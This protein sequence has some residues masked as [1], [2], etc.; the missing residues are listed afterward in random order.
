[1]L[2]VKKS[3]VQVLLSPRIW[4]GLLFQLLKSDKKL[5]WKDRPGCITLAKDHSK[6]LTFLTKFPFPVRVQG[7][8]ARRVHEKSVSKPTVLGCSAP[9]F[10]VP[11]S[12]IG[13]L[14]TLCSLQLSCLSPSGLALLPLC[15]PGWVTAARPCPLSCS[16]SHQLT[17]PPR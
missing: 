16:I 17:Q 4:S 10:S 2:R 6:L 12:L 15:L 8:A 7:L 1:M 14:L 13:A 3:G 9:L 5:I 11:F